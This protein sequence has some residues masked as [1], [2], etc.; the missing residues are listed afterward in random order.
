M[1]P[2]QLLGKTEHSH[3][4]A[5]FAWSQMAQRYGFVWAAQPECYELN[6]RD[7]LAVSCGQS[8]E[9]PELA[10]LHAVH[11][12]G[13]GDAVHGAKAKAEG[14]RSG[15][16]DIFLPVVTENYAGLYI[17]LKV[18]SNRVV[19]GSDQEKFLAYANAE[20]YAATEA[21]GYHEARNYIVSYLQQRIL[22]RQFNEQR[23]QENTAFV[24]RT[25]RN[26]FGSHFPRNNGTP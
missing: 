11:N 13:H 22:T 16:S 25:L 8:Y 2:E 19:K 12:Q 17:E 18:G 26:G 4:R 5:L 10:W 20:G 24:N 15:I 7:K 6:A 9:I 14:V 3:Q 1:T 23:D 21:I